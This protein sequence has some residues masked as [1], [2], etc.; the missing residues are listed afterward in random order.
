M[1]DRRFLCNAGFRKNVRMIESRQVPCNLCGSESLALLYPDELG[2][3]AARVDYDF[4]PQTRKTYRI[5]KCEE[6]GLIFTNPMPALQSSY[7][8]TEDETYLR[9]RPQRVRTAE[10][11]I[12]RLRR[13]KDGGDLLDVGCSTGILLDAAS[14][15]FRVEG[16]ELS[17]WAFDQASARHK[18]YR[19]PLRDLD[20]EQTYDVVTLMGVIE[21]FENPTAEIQAIHDVLK[22]G[23]LFVVYTGDVDAWLPRI[24][25]KKW[26]WYQGMHLFYFSRST[27]ESL[28]N[29]CGFNVLATDNHCT[30]FE[31]YSLGVSLRRY[32]IGQ[33]VHPL[34]NLPGV[35][36]LMVPLK[37]SG[38]MLMFATKR[39]G[40][41]SE[42]ADDLAVSAA[43]V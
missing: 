17:Q 2:D 40:A 28:L 15:H 38:E 13:Y 8:E 3:K 14:K 16:I 34:L 4:S 27:C 31:L 11:L 9:S 23:G 6:C 25:G 7:E 19:R 32:W 24:L 30:Y 42:S 12:R 20:L 26:W 1:R 10:R 41:P 36:N 37:L 43:M 35:R 22:P 18:V 33:L 5:V 21:H 29:K 39:G